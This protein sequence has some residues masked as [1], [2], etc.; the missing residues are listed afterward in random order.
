MKKIIENLYVGDKSEYLSAVY[1]GAAIV[2]A[3]NNG[4]GNSYHSMVGKKTPDHPDYLYKDMGNEIYL[5]MIDGKDPK[6]IHDDMI[7]AAVSFIDRKIRDHNV[8]IYCSKGQ[9]RAPS[10]A[11]IYMMDKGL[12]TKDRAGILAFH[13]LYPGYLPG[14]GIKKY[15]THRY[16]LK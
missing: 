12:I 9:S 11:M 2:C 1:H 16:G 3:M 7:N 8:F 5:N 10:L 15:I 13:R 14:E 6:Y 4:A